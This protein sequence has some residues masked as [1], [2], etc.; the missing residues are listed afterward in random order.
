[1]V[2]AN[3]EL[4]KPVT[5]EKIRDGIVR[6]PVISF[7]SNE[8]RERMKIWQSDEASESPSTYLEDLYKI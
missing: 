5:T 3:L 8:G 7:E 2:L 4:V 6:T 1:M